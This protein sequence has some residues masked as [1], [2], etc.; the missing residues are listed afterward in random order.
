ME[1]RLIIAGEVPPAEAVGSAVTVSTRPWPGFALGTPAT[2]AGEEGAAAVAPGAGAG[3]WLVTT[4]AGGVEGGTTTTG[5]GAGC[6]LPHA[7]SKASA[8]RDAE[9]VTI[10]R[11]EASLSM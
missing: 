8:A 9:K 2:G 6:L 10:L 1:M 5:G 7:A 3:V 11:M 4:G